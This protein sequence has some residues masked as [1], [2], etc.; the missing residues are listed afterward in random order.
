M[1]H[2]L[3]NHSFFLLLFLC[4]IFHFLPRPLHEVLGTAVMM[5]FLYHL[6]RYGGWW[7]GLLRGNTV[8]SP[9]GKLTSLLNLLLLVLMAAVI[10]SGIMISN[11]IFKDIIP[12]GWRTSAAIHQLHTS[13]CFALWLMTGLHVGL[14]LQSW[15]HRRLSSPAARR[16]ALAVAFLTCVAGLY[17]SVLHRIGDRLLM[18]HIFATPALKAGP[19][20]YLGGLLAVFGL[21]TVIGWLLQRICS[22]R[23]D[24]KP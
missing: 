4:M 5:P 17:S 18:K 3:G 20:T 6:W 23:R 11:Y 24:N 9:L 15:I 22:Q 2:L 8:K 12:L 21:Y 16:P 14:H 1:K 19:L 13:S 7:R 10:I